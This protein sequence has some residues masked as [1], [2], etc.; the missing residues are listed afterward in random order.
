MAVRLSTVFCRVSLPVFSSP[1]RGLTVLIPPQDC[2]IFSRKCFGES[3][4]ATQSYKGAAHIDKTS[5]AGPMF[6]G[7]HFYPSEMSCFMHHS[8]IG[9]P[10]M[11]VVVTWWHDYVRL[12]ALLYCSSQ[13]VAKIR[14]LVVIQKLAI[15]SSLLKIW[16]SFW[17]VFWSS[18]YCASESAHN[19][20]E[21]ATLA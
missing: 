20:K 12:P 17:F 3:N 5:L 21:K 18:L 16:I 14:F 2:S 1:S 13:I 9:Y 10:K 6:G 19:L 15:S 8:Q 4:I 11:N 7:F